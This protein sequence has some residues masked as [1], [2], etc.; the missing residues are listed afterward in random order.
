[1]VIF[2]DKWRTHP[3]I[4]SL[5]DPLFAFGV[6]RVPSP[7]LPLAGERVDQRSE[8]RVSKISR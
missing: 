8:V 1:M 5:A 7:S 6:K 4:V 3:G 2:F